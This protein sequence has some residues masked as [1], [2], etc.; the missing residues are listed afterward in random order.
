MVITILF[1]VPVVGF[2][3]GLLLSAFW[4]LVAFAIGS[5][6]NLFLGIVVGAVVC[7]AAL[8]AHLGLRN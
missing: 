6:W 7:L 4:G 2:I 8:G 1:N 3:L 5:I